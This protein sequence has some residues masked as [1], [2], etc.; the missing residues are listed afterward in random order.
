MVQLKYLLIE[1]NLTSSGES[2]NTSLRKWHLISDSKDSRSY[3]D[4]VEWGRR[5]VFQEKENNMHNGSE[6]RTRSVFLE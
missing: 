5:G 6:A 4:E 1:T 3:L 2:R